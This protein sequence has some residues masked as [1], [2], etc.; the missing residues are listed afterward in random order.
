M[1]DTGSYS[2]EE[3]LI[4][5]NVKLSKNETIKCVILC[6]LHRMRWLPAHPVHHVQSFGSQN[7]VCFH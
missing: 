3:R 4:M 7:T 5:K 1:T 6:V 2:V